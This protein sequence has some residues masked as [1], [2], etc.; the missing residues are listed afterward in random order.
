[1]PGI[2]DRISLLYWNQYNKHDTKKRYKGIFNR[3]HLSHFHTVELNNLFP[4][5]FIGFN[6]VFSS[7]AFVI[8]IIRREVKIKQHV[9]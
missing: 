1:M 3:D 8:H 4:V 7:P 6:C 5:F 2:S 9:S